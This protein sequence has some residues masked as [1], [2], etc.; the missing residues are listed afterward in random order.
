[1]VLD[2]KGSMP[3]CV[4]VLCGECILT[5]YGIVTIPFNPSF[6]NRLLSCFEWSVNLPEYCTE[7]RRVQVGDF[8]VKC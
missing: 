4:M 8:S 5:V 3:V 2:D 6:I 7:S 1:M